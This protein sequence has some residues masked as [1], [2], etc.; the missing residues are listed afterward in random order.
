MHGRGD[1]HAAGALYSKMLALRSTSFVALHQLGVIRAQQGRV[2]EAAELMARAL[3]INPG[4]IPALINYE[5]IL[6]AL[7]RYDEVLVVCNQALEVDPTNV[8][9]LHNRAR[10]LMQLDRFGEALATYEQLLAVNATDVGILNE[11]A[12]AMLRAGRAA[13]AIARFDSVLSL[14]PCNFEALNNRGNILRSEKRFDEALANYDAALSVRDDA[15]E[16]LNNRGVALFGALRFMEAL[17]SYGRALTLKPDFAEALN[18]RGF[19]LRELQRFNEAVADYDRAIQIAPNYIAALVNRGKALCES[20]RVFEGFADFTHASQ[21]LY[22]SRAIS[23]GRAP[24]HRERHDEEQHRYICALHDLGAPKKGE[25]HLVGGKMLS[26]PAINAANFAAS[27]TSKWESQRLRHV[28]I[29]NFLTPQAL[30]ELRQFCWGS[31]VWRRTY[32]NGYLGA[33]PESGFACPLLAQIADELPKKLPKIFGPHALRYIWAFKYDSQ[34]SGTTV[35]ADEAAI[36]VN[37]WITPDDANL[38]KKKG[39]LVL[40][41]ACAPADWGFNEFNVSPGEVQSLLEERGAK[42]TT[43]PYRSN[44]AVIFDSNLFHQTDE[45]MFEQGYLNRRINITMLFGRRP[46]AD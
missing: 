7:G 12:A 43:I 24:E 37:F 11:S 23:G 45:I 2:V 22:G 8:D 15:P 1:L 40:W 20:H 3:R 17:D 44:R 26:G 10:A 41:D 28:V 42:S 14:E 29:D 25:F 31:T 32:A 39:G 46:T 35:H 36:N 27:S 6:S 38:N 5:R 4:S 18:N 30:E 16:V 21:L 9:A 13:E 19:L 34:L 33:F